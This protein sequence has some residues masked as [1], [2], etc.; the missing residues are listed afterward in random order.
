MNLLATSG[1]FGISPSS[2]QLIVINLAAIVVATSF[3][4][5]QKTIKWGGLVVA[6]VTATCAIWCSGH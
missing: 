6:V 1:A 2:D 4:A 3:N 5:P